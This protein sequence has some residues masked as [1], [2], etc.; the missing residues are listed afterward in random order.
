MLEM[1][2]VIGLDPDKVERYEHRA[3]DWCLAGCDESP[4]LE[5]ACELHA[6]ADY[7]AALAG[8]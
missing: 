3:V 6:V 5:R 8:R 4:A 1:S 2:N 7:T